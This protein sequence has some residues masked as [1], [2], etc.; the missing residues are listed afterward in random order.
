MAEGGE[1]AE[2]APELEAPAPAPEGEDA[3]PGADGEDGAAET[4]D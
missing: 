3:L 1:P 4:S 2:D